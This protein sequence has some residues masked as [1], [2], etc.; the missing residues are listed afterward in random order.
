MSAEAD[1]GFLHRSKHFELWLG[2]TRLY[3]WGHADLDTWETSRIELPVSHCPTTKSVPAS[4]LEKPNHLICNVTSYQVVGALLVNDYY[5]IVNWLWGNSSF[6][7]IAAEE[8]NSYF[9][10]THRRLSSST[11]SI[12][13]TIMRRFRTRRY[14][15][16][17][18][19]SLNTHTS[20]KR[21][22]QQWWSGR[23]ANKNSKR[24]RYSL[25]RRRRKEVSCFHRDQSPQGGGTAVRTLMLSMWTFLPGR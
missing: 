19:R 21:P 11:L 7:Y 10:Q 1:V 12:Y 4:M 3:Q 24:E 25:S 13:S 14:T 9:N 2:G 5:L 16:R 22:R 17:D 6:N 18:G 15:E 20:I 23:R 8:L